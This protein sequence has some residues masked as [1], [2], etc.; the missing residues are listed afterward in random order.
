[1]AGGSIIGLMKLVGEFTNIKLLFTKKILLSTQ[2]MENMWMR[3]K[4]KLRWQFGTSEDVFPSYL[5]ELL[6]RNRFQNHDLFGAFL[7]CVTQ[8]QR[9]RGR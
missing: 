5:H 7:A 1:M 6:W 3:A 4:R 2:N 9:T 8:Q